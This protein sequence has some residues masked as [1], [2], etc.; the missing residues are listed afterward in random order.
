MKD[1][2]TIQRYI[3]FQLSIIRMGDDA[4][5]RDFFQDQKDRKR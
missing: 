3:F 5:A 1:K 2:I 4:S